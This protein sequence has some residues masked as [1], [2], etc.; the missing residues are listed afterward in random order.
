MCAADP[1]DVGGHV[2]IEFY[3]VLRE[4]S[5]YLKK[6]FPVIRPLL[7]GPSRSI[8]AAGFNVI[9]SSSPTSQFLGSF[10]PQRPDNGT[11]ITTSTH[12]H[13]SC[14]KYYSYNTTFLLSFLVFWTNDS[15]PCSPNS[16]IGIIVSIPPPK[17]K[18]D[19]NREGIRNCCYIFIK[20]TDRTLPKLFLCCFIYCYFC[21]VLCIVYFCCSMYCLFCVVLCIVSV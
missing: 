9:N 12:S 11:F 8:T 13:L 17:K 15:G 14:R 16:M 10:R 7:S 5:E 1:V 18:L 21:V 4:H 20:G 3:N 6:L 2:D 19:H